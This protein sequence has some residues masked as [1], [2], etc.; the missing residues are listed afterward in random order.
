M[1]IDIIKTLLA[2]SNIT[3]R[4]RCKIAFS[5]P[6]CRSL[7]ASTTL[8]YIMNNRK[9]LVSVMKPSEKSLDFV[10][11]GKVI[12]LYLSGNNYY[13]YPSLKI[14]TPNRYVTLKFKEFLNELRVNE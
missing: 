5:L 13:Y 4:D 10:F 7:K 8:Q 2:K 9:S 11:T 3:F 14:L 6:L 12:R 1:V